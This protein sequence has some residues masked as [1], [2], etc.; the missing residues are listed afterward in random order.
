[1]RNIRLLLEYE[2]TKYVGWQAQQNGPSIQ[3]EVVEVLKR[4]TGEERVK[5]TGASRTDSGVH[6]AGQ[7]ANFFTSSTMSAYAMVRG[8]NALL[9]SDIAVL[10][11]KDVPETFDARKG[12]SSKTYIYSVLARPMPSPL[13]RRFAWHV[14]KPLDLQVMKEAAGY[15]PGLK[16]FS[17]FRAAHSDARHSLREVLSVRITASANVAGLIAIEVRGRA[18]LRHMVRIMAGTIVAAGLGKI[19]PADV[20]AIIEARDRG[21]APRTAPAKGLLLKKIIYSDFRL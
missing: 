12:A 1:M 20:G 21:A 19:T 5:L 4:L 11:V 7:V 18:F 3:S 15:L 17:S 14:P 13:Q 10:D 9:P 6:A 16:D 2:G 8:L